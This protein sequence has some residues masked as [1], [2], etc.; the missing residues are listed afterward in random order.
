MEGVEHV[1]QLDDSR[2]HWIAKVGGKTA[3]R[4]AKIVEQHPDKHIS[5][6]SE[7][8]K[9]TR[10]TVT[11]EPIGGANADQSLGELSGRGPN[12]SAGLSH[13]PRRATRARR[14]RAVQG[15]DREPRCRKRRLAR[16]GFSGD[17]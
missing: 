12:G 16:R 14:S 4:D 2:L 15:T 13:R 3:K 10:G 11:F 6:I 9:K 7:D 1:E 17:Y 5:W 8:R